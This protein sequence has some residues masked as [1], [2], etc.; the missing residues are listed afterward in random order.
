MEKKRI[1]FLTLFICTF[2]V[3]IG[4]SQQQR[5]EQLRLK[6]ESIVV[7]T[8]GLN[9]KVNLNVNNV[10][11]PDFLRAIASTNEVNLS[12]NPDLNTINVSN[13]FSNVSVVDVLLFLSKEYDLDI[14]FTGNILSIRKLEKE[15]IPYEKREIPIEFDAVNELL[16]VDI[17]N[18]SLYTVFKEITNKTGKNLVFAPGLENYKLTS[19]IQRMPIESAFDK[20]A[21]ANNLTVTKSR[22]NYYLFEGGTPLITSNNQGNANGQQAPRRN[23]RSNFYLK[24]TDTINKKVDVDFENIQISN[25]IYDLGQQFKLDV[26]TSTPLDAAGVA[27]VKAKDI[28]LDLLLDKLLENTEFAFKK[29]R[30]IYYFGK[31]DQVSLRNTVTIPLMY[32]SIEI[33][34]GQSSTSSQMTGNT[35]YSNSNYFG[36]NNGGNSGFNNNNFNNN[37]SNPNRQNINTSSSGFQNHNSKAEA[38]VSILPEEVKKNLDIQTDVELNSFI[39]SGPSQYIEKFRAF[40]KYIDKPVPNINIEVMFIEVNRSATVETGINWGIGENAV[41]TQGSLFPETD[42]TLGAQTI[43]KIINSN[44]FGSLN[45]GN[46]VPGFFMNVKAMESNGDIKVRST[47]KISALNGHVANFSAGET[48]YYAVTERNIYGSQN[49]QTS[50]ITNYFPLEAQTAINI[51]PIVSGDGNITMEINVVQSSF[52]GKKVDENAPPGVNSREFTSVVRVGD[53]DLIVLGGLEEVIKNDSGSGVPF[54]ARI[55]VIKWLFSKRKREDTKK[56]LV[57]FIKPTIIF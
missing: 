4:F 22:D 50:E 24:I 48:T 12:I 21:F 17:Q 41:A 47:P 39:V 32:R 36:G 45:L 1:L 3:Q 26:F 53:Q 40:I 27:T 51:K 34:T 54:L 29:D 56:K 30:E 31:L 14:I 35:R 57:V 19:Y 18:D 42:F 23:R 10:L 44:Q 38:L 7:D 20:I 5:I 55:P 11:L 16:S 49:P 9:E 43:N 15:K 52:N 33:M 25:I 28:S 8:P 37:T 46:V 2:F 6:L 13:N